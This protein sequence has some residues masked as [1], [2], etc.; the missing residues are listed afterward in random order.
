MSAALELAEVTV[1]STISNESCTQDALQNVDSEAAAP[2][3]VTGIEDHK[4]QR[5]HELPVSEKGQEVDATVHESTVSADVPGDLAVAQDPPTLSYP[6]Q[7]AQAREARPE[8]SRQRKLRI[9]ASF[10]ALFLAGWK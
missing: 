5:T 7:V 1:G 10:F 2:S 4:L 3:T 6:P 9:S 8:S